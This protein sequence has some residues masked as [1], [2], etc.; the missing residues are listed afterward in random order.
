MK[1]EKVFFLLAFIACIGACETPLYFEEPQPFGSKNKKKFKRNF[2]GSYL[3]LADSSIL[4]IRPT[5]IVQHWN[6]M[7]KIHKNEIDST[8]EI[9]L[10]DGQLNFIGNRIFKVLDETKDS[11][12]M[13]LNWDQTLFKVSEKQLLR[14]YK[15]RYFLNYKVPGGLWELKIMQF[16][17]EG[18]LII[19]KAFGGM[20]NI[21]E[22]KESTAIAEIKNDSNK[23]KHYTL[24]PTK[25]ELKELLKMDLRKSAE[26][27]RKISN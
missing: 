4:E 16:N 10:E 20:K 12:L 23:L 25:K 2:Q 22:I 3:S 13:Q 6:V 27:F 7:V 5:E 8:E 18:I 26:R 19:E 15:G 9:G 21:Q 24:K 14:Y 1:I 11:L 17:K